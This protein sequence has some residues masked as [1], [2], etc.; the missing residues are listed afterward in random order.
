M[1][2]AVATACTACAA[3]VI[4][5][6]EYEPGRHLGLLHVE[7][8]GELECAGWVV[9]WDLYADGTPDVVCP[10]IAATLET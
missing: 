6:E 10:H 7:H 1:S 4:R 8:V 5:G 2:V 9:A 3:G